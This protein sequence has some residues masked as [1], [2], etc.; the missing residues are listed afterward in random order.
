MGSREEIFILYTGNERIN[1]VCYPE[2]QLYNIY[3]YIYIY[4]Y[5]NYNNILYIL[6]T[7]YG[8]GTVLENVQ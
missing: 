4:I 8:G 5:M 2:Q 1:V 3:I 6:S 7:Y